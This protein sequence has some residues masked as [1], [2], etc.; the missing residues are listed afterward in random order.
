MAPSLTRSSQ[1]GTGHASCLLARY[2]SQ[3]LVLFLHVAG[4][5]AIMFRWPVW[6]FE[7]V[8]FA[9]CSLPSMLELPPVPPPSYAK[10]DNIAE[11][12]TF[13]KYKIE[14][15]RLQCTLRFRFRV[16]RKRWRNSWQ[17]PQG[18]GKLVPNPKDL[19]ATPTVFVYKCTCT[20]MA[21]CIDL[22]F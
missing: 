4:S 9:H 17:L 10:D 11:S 1:P 8:C 16:D 18:L 3:R 22:V 2:C 15:K 13:W 5:L 7:A 6:F 20:S 19:R 12:N 21:V 14:I